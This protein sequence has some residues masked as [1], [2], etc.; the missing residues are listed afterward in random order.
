MKA[1]IKNIKK[2]KATAKSEGKYNEKDADEIPFSLFEAIC[3]WAIMTGNILIWAF[4]V[5]QWNIMGRSVNVGP[6]GFHSLSRDGGSDS[7]V[8]T[9]DINKKD[10]ALKNVSPKNCYANPSNPNVCFNLALAC[11]LCV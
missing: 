4:T 9:L 3:C 7:I 10:Q 2:E 11:Y 5:V 6:L 1:F 8:I